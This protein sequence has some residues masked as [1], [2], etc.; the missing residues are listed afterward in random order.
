[1]E[2][3]CV[4]VYHYC[5][6]IL[7]RQPFAAGYDNLNVLFEKNGRAYAQLRSTGQ[8]Q[9]ISMMASTGPAG[10]DKG[11]RVAAAKLKI[12]LIQFVRLHGILFNWARQMQ[13]AVTELAEIDAQAQTLDYASGA[14]PRRPTL[15]MPQLDVDVF[16]TLM[17][18][19][20]EE[21]DHLLLASA[22]GDQLLVRLLVIS[23][24]SVHHTA[25]A[26]TPSALGTNSSSGS[27]ASGV[28]TVAAGAGGAAASPSIPRSG[29]SGDL[30]AILSLE[31]PGAGE[32]SA[33]SATLP[34][35][36][37]SSQLVSCCAQAHPHTVGESLALMF[38][39]SFIN[40]Y[41]NYT[42]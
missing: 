25:A 20:I 27:G 41:G 11:K 22:F 12:F 19:V 5:R 42:I 8:F 21:Y 36:V 39:F 31:L 18:S 32:V 40:K 29:S 2:A 13:S 4:A 6:S 15:T 9:M 7:V 17:H 26:T 35:S 14:L 16:V 1:M 24:F 33:V 3:E 30:A 28:G 23:I 10:G 38:V 34:S 37:A